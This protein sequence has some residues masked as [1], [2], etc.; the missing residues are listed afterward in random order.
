MVL[1]SGLVT[2]LALAGAASGL[3][4]V[5]LAWSIV[6]GFVENNYVPLPSRYAHSL[7]PWALR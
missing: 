1:A 6:V 5:G 2:L 3:L 7:L 4:N